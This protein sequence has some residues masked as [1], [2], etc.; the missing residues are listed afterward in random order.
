MLLLL[1]SPPMRCSLAKLHLTGEEEGLAMALLLLPP[2]APPPCTCA[3]LQR[4]PGPPLLPILPM[5]SARS[6]SVSKHLLAAAETGS[7][8]PPPRDSC[9]P[10]HRE[11]TVSAKSPSS[12]GLA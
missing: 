3:E 5:M 2:A 11:D 12:P 7:P 8:A 6:S 10:L 9:L 4:A 1:P